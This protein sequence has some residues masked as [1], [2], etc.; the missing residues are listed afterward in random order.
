MGLDWWATMGR[1][2]QGRFWANCSNS[3]PRNTKQCFSLGER[4]Y[5]EDLAKKGLFRRMMRSL[6][7]NSA[8]VR[9]IA[10]TN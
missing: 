2:R 8:K 7:R 6:A 4:I 1:S 10:G 9:R 5:F 3:R